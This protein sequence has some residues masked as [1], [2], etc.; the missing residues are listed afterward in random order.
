MSS[1]ET[2]DGLPSIKACG[3]AAARNSRNCKRPHTPA[4]VA[5]LL[6]LKSPAFTLA[7]AGRANVAGQPAMGVRVSSKGHADVSLFFDKE[8]GLL[9]KTQTRSKDD[10]GAEAMEETLLSDYKVVNGTR[11][12]TKVVIYRDGK[13]FLTYWV[14]DC[15]PA[16]KF[17][18]GTFDKP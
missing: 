18:D 1:T 15:K 16:E 5:T 8:T 10:S 9:V 13:S 14:T 7:P 17:A 6:P 12:A 4:G 11:Q 3:D 2:G